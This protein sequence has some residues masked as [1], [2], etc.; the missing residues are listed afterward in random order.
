MIYTYVLKVGGMGV[1]SPL[2]AL[3]PRLV[4]DK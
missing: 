4:A 1:R 2:D 3:A